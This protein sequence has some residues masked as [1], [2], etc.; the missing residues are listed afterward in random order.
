MNIIV[1][2][3]KEHIDLTLP[4]I[5]SLLKLYALDGKAVIVERNGDI[6][7]KKD[8]EITPIAEGDRIELV[9]FVGGG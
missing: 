5:S 9:H 3:K 7:S 8:L 6:V 1:N 2:G 4:T